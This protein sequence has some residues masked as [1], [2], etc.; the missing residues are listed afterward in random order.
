MLLSLIPD[1]A[2]KGIKKKEKKEKRKYVYEHTNPSYVCAMHIHTYI[3]L[4]KDKGAFEKCCFQD[5]DREN[6]KSLGHLRIQNNQGLAGGL[7]L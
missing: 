1:T 6:L 5:W 2:K 3:G 4:Q 7:C